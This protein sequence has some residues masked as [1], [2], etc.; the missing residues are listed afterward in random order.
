MVDPTCIS[1]KGALTVDYICYDKIN[2]IDDLDTKHLTVSRK[3]NRDMY[4]IY[5]Q[6]ANEDKNIK[7]SDSEDDTIKK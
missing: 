6:I 7:D 3:C 1:T 5:V 2:S 4:K